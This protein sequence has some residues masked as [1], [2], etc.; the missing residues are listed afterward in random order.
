MLCIINRSA[1]CKIFTFLFNIYRILVIITSVLQAFYHCNKISGYYSN[2]LV[3]IFINMSKLINIYTYVS[4]LIL[5]RFMKVT[6]LLKPLEKYEFWHV[7]NYIINFKTK[8]IWIFVWLLSLVIL[9]LHWIL[10]L[11]NYYWL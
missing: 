2:E 1:R 4:Y 6:Q 7:F 10:K 8:L 11:F 3:V 5:Y 9:L